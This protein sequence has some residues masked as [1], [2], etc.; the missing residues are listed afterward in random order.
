M[1]AIEN[2]LQFQLNA[3]I[4]NL[5]LVERLLTLAPRIDRQQ[6]AGLR[7]ADARRRARRRWSG[8]R[9]CPPR[10]ATRSRRS[11]SRDAAAPFHIL[12]P[13][14][15]GALM[16]APPRARILPDALHR[17]AADRRDRARARSLDRSGAPRGHV[18]RAR[19]R[20]GHGDRAGAA[21][22]RSPDAGGHRHGARST[23]SGPAGRRPPP[24]WR[25]GRTR[26]AAT[27]CRSCRSTAWRR[28]WRARPRRCAS[29]RRS[30]T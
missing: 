28:T 16:A 3:Q 25:C 11:A 10:N 15:T 6:F 2:E 19:H 18:A 21:A 7:R 9:A 20:P 29:P 30:W 1:A 22:G 17:A 27:R 5:H 8:C 4:T 14:E 13:T 24:R 23:A 12:E 26:F